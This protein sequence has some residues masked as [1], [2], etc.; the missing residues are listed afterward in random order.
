M[1]ALPQIK[2]SNAATRTVMR[3]AEKAVDPPLTVPHENLVGPVRQYSGSLTYLRNKAEIGQ[4]PTSSQLPYAGEYIQQLDNAIRTT[5]FVDQVQFVGDFKMTATEVIQRLTE[6]MRLLG[7]VLG[8]LENEFLNPLVERVFGIMY[9]NGAFEQPPDEIQ[10]QD[11]RIEYQSPLARAQKSQIAQGFQQVI[12]TLEPLAKLGP[13]IASQLFGPID[14]PKLTPALFDWFGVDDALLKS[15]DDQGQMAQQQNMQKMLTQ[16]VPMLA[17][18]FQ[19]GSAGVSHIADA[20]QTAVATSG[21]ANQLP[22]P[23]NMPPANAPETGGQ[24]IQSLLGSL[25][26]GAAA[27]LPLAIG[28]PGQAG[29]AATSARSAAAPT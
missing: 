16:I 23:P 18:A 22:A 4:L 12:A 13:E 29:A 8:R 9:R 21:M 1:T 5:M 27:K 10:N 6:R 14:V 19:Q 15:E 26:G 17:K 3:A 11:M 20:G 25:M 24:D 2:V 28:P 7:P